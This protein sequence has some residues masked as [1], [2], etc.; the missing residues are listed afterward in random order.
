M[1]F[2]LF[3]IG[4][5]W[6]VA[7]M[8]A[9]ITFMKWREVRT[10]R[11]W[12]PVRGKIT[13]SHVEA[14]EVSVSRS[15][16]TDDTE[17][18]NFPA[19]TFEYNVDG[20]K[21][22]GTRYSLRH[23]VGNFRVSETLARYPRGA[24][25]TVFY[26]PSAPGNAVIE[27]TMPEG[28]TKLAAYIVAGLMIGPAALVFLGEGMLDATRPHLPRPQ[29][30][31]VGMF[32]AIVGSIILRMAF[33]QRAVA[34]VAAQ[35][36]TV[37]GRINSSAVEAHRSRDNFDGNWARPWRTVYKSRVRYTYKVAGQNFASDRVAFGAII[38]ATLPALVAGDSGRYSE[39]GTVQVHYDPANPATAVLE[40]RVKG[41]WILWSVAAASL[42]GAAALVGLV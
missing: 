20:R 35:W 33:A 30:A 15:D 31:E 23:Q 21:F 18:R 41:L 7:A 14:R 5:A 36:P 13:S 10:A 37:K 32:L 24:E 38:T 27:R 40:C 28:T 1:Q 11:N 22:E 26:D 25:V 42:A 39:G 16:S 29:N 17:I 12:F 4:F 34:K 3:L 2:K 6:A 19:V 8:F 9:L